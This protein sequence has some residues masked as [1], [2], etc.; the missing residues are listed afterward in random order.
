ML[1]VA[2]FELSLFIYLFAYN[3]FTHLFV[4]LFVC[5]LFIYIDLGL[6]HFYIHSSQTVLQS[7][8]SCI[9]RK[10]NEVG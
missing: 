9:I 4:C 7:S 5:V 2:K 6:V 1:S 8:L 3:L 10:Y